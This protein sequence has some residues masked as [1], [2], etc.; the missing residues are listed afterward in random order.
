MPHSLDDAIAQTLSAGA[1]AHHAGRIGEAKS[2][3]EKILAIVPNHS[4][5]L[6]L[7]GILKF[8][9]GQSQAGIAHIRDAIKSEPN[10]PEFHFNLGT[11]LRESGHTEQAMFVV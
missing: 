3:Y 5:A 7:L 1:E 2:L 10:R 8:Q 11:A 6:H 9:T 4:D